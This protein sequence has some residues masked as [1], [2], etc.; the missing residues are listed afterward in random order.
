M[1]RYSAIPSMNHSGRFSA[2][3]LPAAAEFALVLRDVVLKGVD[4]LVAEDV[5]G[6]FE[7]SGERQHDAA[8]V[9][10]RDAAGALAQS[11]RR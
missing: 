6:R 3:A 2:P 8:L 11:P 9:R 7:R 4:E 5:V 1:D 10:F